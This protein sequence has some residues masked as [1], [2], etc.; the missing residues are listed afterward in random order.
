MIDDILEFVFDTQQLQRY[1]DTQ[2]QVYTQACLDYCS[3]K[4][5]CSF[6]FD[7]LPVATRYCFSVCTGD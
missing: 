7:V 5:L 4:G 2:Q 6:V 3:D 1:V